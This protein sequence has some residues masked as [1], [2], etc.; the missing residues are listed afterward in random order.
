MGSRI[1]RHLRLRGSDEA[2]VRHIALRL[3]DAMRTASLPEAGGRLVLVRRL[4]LGRIP[5]DAAPQTLAL[6]L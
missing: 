6:S 2:V 5:R 4:A 3:E 1:V